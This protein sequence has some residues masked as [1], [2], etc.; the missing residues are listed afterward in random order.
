VGG[1]GV[2]AFRDHVFEDVQLS[3]RAILLRGCLDLHFNAELLGRM[4]IAVLHG[5]PVGIGEGD[6]NH[7]HSETRLGFGHR[8]ELREG[9][10]PGF[11][12]KAHFGMRE[13][14]PCSH[15]HE[16]NDTAKS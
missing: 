8:P 11:F 16:E 9:N 14:G 12:E 5:D 13:W 6:Q 10:G 7:A 15:H 3:G 1:D 4:L 2:I